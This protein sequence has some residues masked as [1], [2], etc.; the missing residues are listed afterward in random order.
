M[1]DKIYTKAF[2]YSTIKE[3]QNEVNDFLEDE[4]V[5]YVDLKYAV[6]IHNWNTYSA[7][8]IYKYIG[9]VYKREKEKDTFHED[10]ILSCY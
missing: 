5:E 4:D 9:K 8:L 6:N 7:V 3:L 1:K 10:N 2:A